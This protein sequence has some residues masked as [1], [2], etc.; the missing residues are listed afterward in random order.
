MKEKT[1][2]LAG[3]CFWG[4]EAYFKTIDGVIDTIVGYAN[5]NRNNTFYELVKITGHAETVKIKYDEETISLEKL[6][7]YFYY[8]ID[9]FSINKQGND[10]GSQYRTGIYSKDQEDLEIART[11][12]EK[13]QKN[14]KNKIQVQVEKLKNFVIAEDY[15]QDY[16][17][18]NPNGY[19]H[20]N[21]SDK[22][23]L[24]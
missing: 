12:L 16:L 19:C 20:I 18:K 8:I 11:F 17:D 15:H 21:I 10:K 5:G 2:Y 14:E 1:I 22:P 6:L 7:E 23:N 4:I 13:K 24:N 3:G 9:P